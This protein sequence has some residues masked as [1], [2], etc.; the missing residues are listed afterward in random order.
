M[1]VATK[2][3]GITFAVD[4]VEPETV[5]LPEVRIHEALRTRWERLESCHDYHSQIVAHQSSH[6]LLAAVHTAFSDHRP[7]VLAPIISGSRSHRG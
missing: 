2:S 4:N 1:P 6:G 3:Y 7:L 5:A